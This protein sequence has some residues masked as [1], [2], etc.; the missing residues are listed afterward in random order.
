LNITAN[1]MK[2]VGK[3]QV[4]V[5]MGVQNVFDNYYRTHLTWGGIPNPGRNWF[6]NLIVDL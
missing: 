4:N 6:V 3:Y 1:W 2:Q 5:D